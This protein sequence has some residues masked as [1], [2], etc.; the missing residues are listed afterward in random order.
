MLIAIIIFKSG[1]QRTKPDV[2]D[3][4]FGFVMKYRPSP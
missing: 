4:K 3:I 1:Q 2:A